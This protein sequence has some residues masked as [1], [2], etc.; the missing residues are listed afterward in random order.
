MQKSRNLLSPELYVFLVETATERLKEF[1]ITAFRSPRE[2][3]AQD[4]GLVRH[5]GPGC[6][7]GPFEN[8]RGNL[9][10]HS[11]CLQCALPLG[12]SYALSLGGSGVGL[13]P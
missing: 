12:K 3:G 7:S 11:S 2:L 8:E 4:M 1:W 10:C 9:R 5:G 13:N 6:K